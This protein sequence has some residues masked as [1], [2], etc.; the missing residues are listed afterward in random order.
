MKYAKIT[1]NIGSLFLILLFIFAFA[2]SSRS[3][4]TSSGQTIYVSV[5]SSIKLG[6]RGSPF[7][8]AATLCIRNT[9]MK[10]SITVVS[11]DYFSSEGKLLR[12]FLETPKQLS[13]LASAEYFIGSTD[14]SGGLSPSFIVKWT[15][16]TEVN[17][18]IVEAVMI[19]DKSGQG[20]SFLSTGKVIKNNAQ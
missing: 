15:A 13:P 1:R 8:L 17:E 7:D 20:I 11:V 19:G 10:Q 4:G 3:F 18:P 6:H 16:V 9:D 5:Y 14:A 2:D 12:H